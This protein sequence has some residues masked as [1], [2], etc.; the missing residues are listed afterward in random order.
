M[1]SFNHTHTHTHKQTFFSLSLSHTHTHKHTHS[2]SPFHKHTHT[3]THTHMHTLPQ[4][5]RPCYCQHY[6]AVTDPVTVS[7]TQQSPTL[8]LSVLLSSHRPCYCQHYPAVTDPVTVSITQQSPT[9]LLSAL[10]SSHLYCQ[11]YSTVTYPE[12]QYGLHQVAMTT[13][14]GSHHEVSLCVPSIEIHG[15]HSL[16]TQ[17][18]EVIT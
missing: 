1:A 11:Y 15:I 9:P 4:S 16:H 7:I 13:C 12:Q 2:L 6:P 8:L 5:H 10:P 17:Q 18:C 14:S 3:H